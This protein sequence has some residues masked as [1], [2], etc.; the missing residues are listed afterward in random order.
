L[1]YVSKPETNGKKC[2]TENEIIGKVEFLINDIFV[3]FEVHIFQ[4]IIGISMGTNCVPSSF[5]SLPVLLWGSFY[6]KI[7]KDKKIQKL[8]PKS[9]HFQVYM[10][11]WKFCQSIIPTLLNG[12]HY[13]TPKE[14]EIKETTETASSSSFLDIN[15]KFDTNVHLSTRLYDKRDDFNFVIPHLSST[16]PIAHACG[17]YIS[18][19]TIYARHCSLYSYFLQC[20]RFLSSKL[21]NQGFFKETPHLIFQNVFRKISINT[22]L[23]RLNILN[24][25]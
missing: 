14:L 11:W 22:L 17:I 8:K 6:T 12:F 16:I 24:L 2:Y 1:T 3:A 23:R 5:R 20:H 13:Y 18:Q 25:R 7:F 15:L 19:L 9:Y 10:Y 21:L 4:Q